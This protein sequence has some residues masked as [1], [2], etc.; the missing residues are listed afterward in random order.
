[1]RLRTRDMPTWLGFGSLGGLCVV[2]AGLVANPLLAIALPVGLLAALF[3]F[4]Q[5]FL[6]VVALS[7]FSHLDAVEKMFFGFLPISA[8]KLITASAVLTM[9]LRGAELRGHVRTVLREPII[10]CGICLI[11]LGA[12][13]SLFAEDKRAALDALITIFSL[14]VLMILVV[15][16]ATTTERITTLIYAVALTSL[17]SASIL[18][19]EIGTGQTL[20][21]QSEAATTARTAEGFDR[22]SGGSDYNPT[23]AASMLLF[24]VIFALIHV[25]ESPKLRRV[26]VT[27]LAIGTVAVVLSFARS[28]VIAYVLIALSL[29]WRYRDEKFVP[30]SMIGATIAFLI[31]IPFIPVEYWARLASIV[32]AGGGADWT[33]G[34]RLSYNLIGLDLLTKSPIVGVGPGNFPNHFTDPEYRFMPGRTLLGRELHNMYLSV[35][36]QFG[37]ASAPF[38]AMIGFTYSRL[39]KVARMPASPQYRAIA[40]ATAYGFAAYLIASLFLPNEYTKY[41]WLLCALG[42]ALYHNNKRARDLG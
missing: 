17:V 23:T 1:M 2:A 24:G 29:I 18:I 11:A 7:V 20:V 41:T 35:M 14:Q 37:L 34:R 39:L 19:V 27:M 9:I 30:I 22:S 33:L 36:V 21:A 13:C 12:I 6:G 38:F 25:I 26:M 42:A 28:A 31:A 40:L 3:L 10:A 4:A 5:P 8:F 32:G 16:F 15:V